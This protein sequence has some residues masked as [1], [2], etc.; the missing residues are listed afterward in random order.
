MHQPPAFESGL[1]WLSR[2]IAILLFMVGPGLFG[3]FI[4][5]KL[6]TGFFTP[7]GIFL[8]MGLATYLLV[9][10]ARKLTPP[11]RGT[12]IPFEDEP[13]DDDRA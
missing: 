9:L 4:D 11:A 10:L 3:A 1:Q 8:G 6:G 12:P 7:A 5:G 2:T 13:T